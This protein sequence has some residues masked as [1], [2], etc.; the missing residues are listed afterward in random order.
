M[1]NSIGDEGDDEE[2]KDR[3]DD[4]DDEVEKDVFSLGTI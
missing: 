1:R 3:I 2:K 4:S